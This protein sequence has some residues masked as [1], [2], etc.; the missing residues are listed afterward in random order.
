MPGQALAYMIGCLHILSLREHV[1][2]EQGAAF[3]L[4]AFHDAVL[5]GGALPLRVL[6]AQV[7]GALG[8]SPRSSEAQARGILAP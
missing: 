4:P 1:K 5:G 3:S 2:A 7:T 8:V 6:D